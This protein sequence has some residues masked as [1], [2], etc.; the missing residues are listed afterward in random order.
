MPAGNAYAINGTGVTA[1]DEE[2]WTEILMGIDLRGQQKRSIYWQLEWRKTVGNSCYLDWM[3]YDN[4]VLTGLTTRP[5]NR[6]D[7]FETYTDVICQSVVFRHRHGA[8][9][10]IVATFLV[11]TA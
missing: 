2:V 11:N 10:E 4:T 7:E 9:S 6:L 8:A 5:R 3:D 1:P